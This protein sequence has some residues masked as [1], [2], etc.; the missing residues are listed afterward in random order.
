M[1]A[2]ILPSFPSSRVLP[3]SGASR[4]EV[5]PARL[6]ALDRLEERLEVP[7]SETLAAPALDHLEEEGGAVLHRLGEE[8]QEVPLLVPVDQETQLA[9]PVQVLR[10][11]PGARRKR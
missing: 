9:D 1:K 4:S 2:S 6:L 8:L 7:L 3:A 11:R 5:A 10:D